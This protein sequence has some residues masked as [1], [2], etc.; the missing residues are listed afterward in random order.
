MSEAPSGDAS[1]IRVLSANIQAGA[2]TRGYGDYV[3]RPWTHVLPHREKRGN[4]QAMAEAARSFDIVG[5][6]ETDPGSLRSG[7]LNQ[8]HYMA[9]QADFPYWSHQ[10]NRAMGGVATSANG[11]LCRLE[12]SEIRDYALPGKLPGRGVLWVRFGEAE[13]SLLVLITHLSLGVKS[14]Q[15]QLGFLAELLQESRHGVVM[16]DLN[17]EASETE[18]R[19]LFRG[20]RLV[21]P[22]D[23]LPSFPSW[24]PQRAIDHI[25][26][27]SEIGIQRRWA[28]AELGSDHL[29]VAAELS[30]PDDVRAAIS[31]P[32][33]G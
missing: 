10:R 31:A 8:T 11:V 3:R 29:A 27:T 14:R 26:T 1:S 15:A 20:T 4:L 22:E 16:G 12:P 18:L 21:P 25:L 19:P 28:L 5:L 33:T 13:N 17:C 23:R 2:S 24:R 7:L 32:A 9:E 30:V 6:Q